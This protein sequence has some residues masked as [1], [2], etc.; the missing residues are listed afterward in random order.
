MVED[1]EVEENSG[2]KPDGEKEAESTAEK[3]TGWLDE[4]SNVNLLLG[5]IAQFTT[6]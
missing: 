3:D 1:F 2:P 6:L 5:Y 4:V